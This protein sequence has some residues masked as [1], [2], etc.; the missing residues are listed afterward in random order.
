MKRKIWSILILILVV[1]GCAGLVSACKDPRE[2]ISISSDTE[3]IEL[4]LGDVDNEKSIFQVSI[5]NFSKKVSGLVGFF[6][7]NECVKVT[8]VETNKESDTARCEITAVRAGSGYVRA[9]VLDGGASVDIP[10][11]VTEK[12]I[13]ISNKT[14]NLPYIVKGEEPKALVA[15][16]LI[17]FNPTSTSQK[18]LIYEIDGERVTEFG[19]EENDQRLSVSVT[20][21]SVV[22]EN[23]RTTFPLRLISPMTDIHS[24]FG[25]T[26]KE[27]VELAVNLADKSSAT[28]DIVVTSM[29]EKIECLNAFYRGNDFSIKLIGEDHVNDAHKFTFE[30]GG[31]KSDIEESYT[32]R[33][34]ISNQYSYEISKEIKI[35][36][37]SVP[38]NIAINLQ[39]ENYEKIKVF[40]YNSSMSKGTSLN[41]SVVPQNVR[42][43]LRDAVISYDPTLITVY[44]SNKKA[45]A[46][47][48][49]VLSGTNLWVK[50]NT[51]AIGQTAVDFFVEGIEGICDNLYASVPV[52]V[53]EGV[54]GVEG[55]DSICLTLDADGSESEEVFKYQFDVLPSGAY[56]GDVWVE[57]ASS[58]IAL[59]LDEGNVVNIKALSAGQTSFTITLQNGITKQ[60]EVDVISPLREDSLV[61]DVPTSSENEFVGSKTPVVVGRLQPLDKVVIQK[62]IAYEKAVPL[63]FNYYPLN[64]SISEFKYSVEKVS[65]DGDNIVE[66]VNNSLVGKG[67]GVANVK[68][69]VLYNLVENG[70]KIEKSQVFEFKVEVYVAVSQFYFSDTNITVADLN[71]VGFY[72]I[73]DATKRLNTYIYP[74]NATYGKFENIKWVLSQGRANAQNPSVL[75]N[76]YVT[77]NTLTGEITGRLQPGI[78]PNPTEITATLI[79]QANVYSVTI[80]INVVT[81]EQVKSIIVDNVAIPGGQI[82]LSA[83][84]PTFSILAHAIDVTAHNKTLLYKFIAK[85]EESAQAVSVDENGIVRLDVGMANTSLAGG[86]IRISAQ[87]SYKNDN[88]N[89]QLYVDIPVVIS[90]GTKESPYQISTKQEL[91]AINT[92][93]AL[94]KYYKIVGIIDLKGEEIA[95][96]GVLAGGLVGANGAK[97][98]GINL[99]SDKDGRVGLFSEISPTGS[100]SNIGFAGSINYKGNAESVGLV[101]G[102]NNGEISNVKVEL[103]QSKV[104][105]LE[106]GYVGGV[107]GQNNASITTNISPNQTNIELVTSKAG[108]TIE[109]YSEGEGSQVHVGGAVG[110]NTVDG[111]IARHIMGVS[112]YNYDGYTTYINIYTNNCFSTG[113]VVGLN[114]GTLLGV[115][116]AGKIVGDNNVG[117]VVGIMQQGEI[118][119]W[120]DGEYSAKTLSNVFIK[121]KDAVGGFA[122]S[123]SGGT[124]SNA[125]VEVY[126]ESIFDDDKVYL[127]SASG[128]VGGFVGSLTAGIISNCYAA[129]FRSSSTPLIQLDTL[130]ATKRASAFAGVNSGSIDSSCYSNLKCV[131]MKQ[132]AIDEN[133]YNGSAAPIVPSSIEIAV[134]QNEMLSDGATT[135]KVMYLEFMQALNS[136][137]Q[138]TLNNKV[139]LGEY[140]EHNLLDA[141]ML[142]VS[143]NSSIIK[144]E[145]DG[146]M[147]KGTGLCELIISSR[148][149]PSLTQ[150]IYVYVVNYNNKEISLSKE[151]QNYTYYI[152]PETIISLRRD[153]V[154]V[155][156]KVVSDAMFEGVEL[157]ESSPY[158][159]IVDDERF[160][161]VNYDNLL[162][163]SA[164]SNFSSADSNKLLEV[165]LSAVYTV[166][167]LGREFKST[168]FA[169]LS[170][171]I[172]VLEGTSEINVN[173]TEFN[174]STF[175][176]VIVDVDF[177]TSIED[178]EI[179]ITP[180]KRAII[181]GREVL[182][183]EKIKVWNYNLPDTKFSFTLE[184][185]DKNYVGN[186]KLN[187]EDKN[188][189]ISKVLNFNVL[190]QNVEIASLRFF[191]SPPSDFQPS[192]LQTT[193][194][195][196]I[197]T[198]GKAGII[199]IDVLPRFAKLDYV[200]IVNDASNPVPLKFE[201]IKF[202]GS[203]YVKIGGST[204]TDNGLRIPISNFTLN[205]EIQQLL[206]RTMIVSSVGDNQTLK[207]NFTTSDGFTKNLSL[208]TK[209]VEK[210]NATMENKN[211]A[212]QV[213]LAKGLD[214]KLNLKAVGFTL[215]QAV[216]EDSESAF[217]IL[218][219]SDQVN[220][221]VTI[222]AKQIGKTTL[223]IYGKK[224]IDGM[225]IRSEVQKIIIQVVEFV[226]NGVSFDQ[227]EIQDDYEVVKG[228]LGVSKQLKI[229]L[230][231]GYNVEY[232]QTNQHTSAMLIRFIEEL[233]A[234]GCFDYNKV[235]ED[236]FKII[237]SKNT[238]VPLKVMNA[239]D[240]KSRFRFSVSIDYD[241]D[242]APSI[243]GTGI[244]YS[245]EMKM[246]VAQ[247]SS[248]ESMIPIS[249]YEEFI[250]MKEGNFYILT[251][252]IEISQDHTPLDVK[253]GGFDGNNKNI[254]MT[255]YKNTED[256]QVEF[257]LFKSVYEN[258][259]IQNVK[260]L[261][262]NFQT[263]ITARDVNFGFIAANNY[264]VIT[265]CQV[266]GESAKVQ[267]AE[268]SSYAGSKQVGVI[269]ANNYGYITNSRV[270]V[271]IFSASGNVGGIA[272]M[273]E[274]VISSTYV[275]NSTIINNSTTADVMTGGIVADNRVT[276]KIWGSYIE[277][278]TKVKDS[279]AC[280]SSISI[281]ANSKIGA[282]VYKNAGQISDSYSN[283]HIISGSTAGGF[284]FE[285]TVSGLISNCFSLSLLRVNMANSYPFV[286]EDKTGV[287]QTT[288]GTFK[289]CY[290]LFDINNWHTTGNVAI[291]GIKALNG[292]DSFKDAENFQSFGLSSVQSY[293]KGVW[294]LYRSN[295]T[296]HDHPQLISANN[297]VNYSKQLTETTRDD[298][299]GAVTYN[300][301][302]LADGSKNNPFII[303]NARDF[304]RYMLEYANGT[305]NYSYFRFVS[306]I[307]YS[308]E[309]YGV[310]LS[311][312]Y[313]INFCGEIDGNGMTISNFVINSQEKLANAGLFATLGSQKYAG[314]V[315]NVTLRPKQINTPNAHRVGVLAGSSIG[316]GA[317]NVTVAPI[318][319]NYGIVLKGIYNVGGIFGHMSSSAVFTGQVVNC[320]SSISV[321]A[322][323]LSQTSD[324]S[325]EG[326]TAIFLPTE[327]II[328]IEIVSLAGGLVGF[329]E[330]GKIIYSDVS[331]D[332]GVIAQIAG[333][334]VG[335]N[336]QGVISN[337]V[338][339]VSDGQFI[340]SSFVAGGLVGYNTGSVYASYIE[341]NT[342]SYFKNGSV[343]PIAVGALVGICEGTVD[344]QSST[345]ITLDLDNLDIAYVGGLVGIL[346]KGTVKGYNI[347]SNI[348]GA[349]RVGGV[350]GK[351]D[352]TSVGIITIE[353]C[354]VGGEV[355]TTIQVY[356]IKDNSCGVL[357]GNKVERSV[358]LVLNSLLDDVRFSRTWIGNSDLNTNFQDKSYEELKE[359]LEDNSTFVSTIN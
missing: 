237:S 198:P 267:L 305:T 271:S 179:Y 169:T 280:D 160:D 254:I 214:Y 257:G 324:E 268:S 323:A 299:T 144:I 355:P 157:V 89:P 269:V 19:V 330:G 249:T 47:G 140:L 40:N 302:N 289:N 53:Y 203:N 225:E 138:E 200:E 120:E 52:E 30:I 131:R 343:A 215:D 81:Y 286:A 128:N 135:Y 176:S 39:T 206:I 180:N 13:S 204:I 112:L 339:R 11:V 162:A 182:A 316:G 148:Y 86:Y 99:T 166:N 304:E 322:T 294:T 189:T 239:T 121:A 261:A 319:S 21:I 58:I 245:T 284:V 93:E 96:L 82:S 83:G 306:D 28:V 167:V 168:S 88:I 67:E 105:L 209:H 56:T 348:K 113:G 344:S 60:V 127:L 119:S 24:Y 193:P 199:A 274:G 43:D 221:V 187:I 300:Y 331:G 340:R 170:T 38:K 118:S 334:L 195:T 349:E 132:G 35:S 345:D 258:S 291:A 242:G 185:A 208:V 190:Q 98:I 63:I 328:N 9:T 250:S 277:G 247:I 165:T 117:G 102:I 301:S 183:N 16:D 282:F 110:F 115:A 46:S 256:S 278:G 270:E 92:P 210:V 10:F 308:D 233:N 338:V 326:T 65:G 109:V 259:I 125:A 211:V 77:F 106:S 218:S 159:V 341:G 104:T 91:L 295:G 234:K 279:L 243:S 205:G 18:E 55:T 147:L 7:S 213:Y 356:G 347:L 137:E 27:D 130:D 163:V 181:N 32:F 201:Q 223:Q 51:G 240:S 310:E 31:L 312:L 262:N 216:V 346:K 133:V 45:V 146:L 317:F 25:E 307:D 311:K 350:A 14:D 68:V 359:E 281:R 3:K 351:L 228:Y 1:C 141:G 288:A 276:A 5:D 184:V 325:K 79:D 126:E 142:V 251:K 85:D 26:E 222:S 273:N 352:A 188:S 8:G 287:V 236:E 103:S 33:F 226:V 191:D 87:D 116:S 264:G 152:R 358:T 313:T 275:K 143:K 41:F 80:T 69:E 329:M 164:S 217:N 337:A 107:A 73:S 136:E 59:S 12:L 66:I 62:S 156:D 50:G 72:K 285:N 76:D 84:K 196:S 48:S 354:C 57:A 212:G 70:Q 90:I 336:R 145:N 272:A 23:I 342:S 246:D 114:N 290:Y 2:N 207:V 252:D 318:S 158:G 219:I 20:A 161:S 298:V 150:S 224:E 49:T 327:K 97:I 37:F 129:S 303:S 94:A 321:N 197:I 202:N 17:N 139:S 335:H 4:V 42:A 332:I 309:A 172:K 248:A 34:G 155:F 171:K 124:I 122:G 235:K 154:I 71:T 260:V 151:T 315:K 220:G 238:V 314:V 296:M 44:D 320:A 177:E 173:S 292:I 297:I 153:E 255:G 95:P 229:N 15:E 353:S 194:T 244:N 108:A 123:M 101:C 111:T 54:Q 178:E 75:E 293:D 230:I 333:G 36:T 64:A 134:L 186:I 6:V 78:T 100:I 357:W 283:I 227:S 241:E 175:D 232:D 149:N 263:S 265:N 231:Q 192:D 174:I 253:I 22:D 266:V 29:E 74:L 61:V